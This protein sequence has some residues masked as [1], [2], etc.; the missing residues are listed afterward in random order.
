VAGTRSTDQQI[1]GATAES[2]ANVRPSHVSESS[3]TGLG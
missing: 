1:A 3:I 2:P